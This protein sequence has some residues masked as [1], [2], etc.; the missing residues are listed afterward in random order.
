MERR[1]LRRAAEEALVMSVGRRPVDGKPDGRGAADQDF[2]YRW[3]E[4]DPAKPYVYDQE[5]MTE[6]IPV[7]AVR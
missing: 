6:P 1:V 5:P 4:S 2:H 3:I 7:V